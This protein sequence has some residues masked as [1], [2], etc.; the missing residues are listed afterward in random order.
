M[1]FAGIGDIQQ[2]VNRTVAE[3]A[4]AVNWSTIAG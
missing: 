3:L 1:H 4:G 2:K